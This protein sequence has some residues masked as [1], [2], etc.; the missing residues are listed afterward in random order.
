MKLRALAW[1]LAVLPLAACTTVNLDQS[2]KPVQAD[3]NA[4]G[5]IAKINLAYSAEHRAERQKTAEELLA[6]PLS[7]DQA[8]SLAVLNSPQFQALLAEHLRKG[9]DAAQIGRIANPV[10]TF[11]RVTVQNGS[12]NELEIGRMLT[13]GLLDL[14]SLP[15]RQGIAKQRLQDAQLNLH[16]EVLGHLGKVRKAWVKAVAA[17]QHLAYA[18]QVRES[19]EA[20]AELARRMQTVGNFNK[21]DRARQQLFYADATTRL[22]VAE[23][24]ATASREELI[25]LLGLTDEQATRLH[26]PDRLPDLPKEPAAPSQLTPTLLEKRLDV[27]LAKARLNAA[28]REQGLGKIASLTDIELGLKRDTA[29]DK[30]DGDVARPR[31]F[32]LEVRL[33]IFDWGNLKRESLNA[34]TL[35]AA[36]Q[37]DYTVRSASSHLRQNY[38]QYRSRYD[39]ARHYQDEVIP[40]R[41]A[42]SDENLLRYNGMLIGVFE[43]LADSRDQVATVIQALTAQE[44]FWM[45]HADLQAAQWGLPQHLMGSNGGASSIEIG[46]SAG[47]ASG[48]H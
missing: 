42:I 46:S 31:G 45:A 1:A 3:L 47:G 26:L 6:K 25:R 29:Y 7:Q 8:L 9:N 34:Q 35:A 24:D 39:I 28:G 20:S 23:L 37:F 14:V 32:E 19:A 15:M 21:L 12:N 16:A 44:Q 2:L 48:G 40:L 27:Q 22:A 11:E 10:F 38:A 13:F 30:A 33:P 17:K 43:L 18:Q 4:T 41:K 5:P 36:N